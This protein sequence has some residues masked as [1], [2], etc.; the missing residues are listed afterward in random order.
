MKGASM[1]TLYSHPLSSYCWKVLIALYDS[2]IPFEAKM[3][4][5]G[6]KDERAAYLKLSPFGKIPSLRDGDRIILETSIMIEYLAMTFPEAVRLIPKA[7]EAALKVRSLDRFFDLY[8]NTPMGKATTDRLRPA[9]K[10]DAFGVAAAMNDMRTAVG[11]V[12]KELAHGD[13]EAGD[14]FTMA[15]CAAAPALYYVNTMIPFA[16]GYP[17]TARYLG[18]LIERPSVARVITEAK[19]YFHMVPK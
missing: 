3:V 8:L 1:L 15:D 13:W 5:L 4:N 9:D 12:E 17:N 16:E 2:G 10:R 19:P 6:D 11:V 14:A 7:P 18:R